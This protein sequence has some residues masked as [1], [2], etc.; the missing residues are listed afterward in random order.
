MSLS[1]CNVLL[2]VAY[3]FCH[4]RKCSVLPL[5]LLEC[6]VLLRMG[7]ELGLGSGLGLGLGSDVAYYRFHY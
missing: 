4:H 6:S 1:E 3:Y 5:S 2:D 7:L